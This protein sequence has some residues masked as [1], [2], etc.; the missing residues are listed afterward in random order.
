MRNSFFSRRL[1]TALDAA[2]YTLL[3][4]VA[5]FYALWWYLFLFGE[6][7]QLWLNLIGV[8]LARHV[9]EKDCTLWAYCNHESLVWWYL[10]LADASWVALSFVVAHAFVVVV[11]SQLSILA[12]R[13]EM[14]SFGCQVNRVQLFFWAFNWSDDCAV[15]LLPV[16]Y[17]SVWTSC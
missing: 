1:Y 15:I 8:N 9:P 3:V 5:A 14:L 10:Y 11:N 6:S 13:E 17:L 7:R 12:A 2:L 4:T 16:S